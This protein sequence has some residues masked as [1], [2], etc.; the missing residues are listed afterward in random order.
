MWENTFLTIPKVQDLYGPGDHGRYA[1]KD[2]QTGYYDADYDIWGPRFDGQ[3]IP[4]YDGPVSTTETFTTTF[5]NGSWTG[6][7]EPTPW[8]ARGKDNLQK[9]LEPGL[10]STNNIAVSASGDKYDLRFSYSHTRKAW[11]QI[12]S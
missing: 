11:F 12:H 8:V 7:I 5:P 10:I 1:Y 6:N 2:G 9:F 3:P 4:Q